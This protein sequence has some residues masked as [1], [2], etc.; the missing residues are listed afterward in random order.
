MA[1]LTTVLGTVLLGFADDMLDLPWRYKL[2]FPFFIVAPL[3]SAFSGS[4]SIG[5]VYPFSL[6]LGSSL[7]LSYLF[8]LYI[9]LL[10]IYCTNTINIYAGINGLEVGTHIFNSGQSII[11]AASM[12]IYFFF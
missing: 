11:A 7:D 2:I 8:Y 9:I 5:I 12:L 10:G 6:M 4:T 3:L 1:V